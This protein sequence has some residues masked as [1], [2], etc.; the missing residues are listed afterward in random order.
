MLLL[1]K[2]KHKIRITYKFVVY[3]PL[4]KPGW[5]FLITSFIKGL[6]NFCH[7]HSDVDMLLGFEGLDCM[8]KLLSHIN[9]RKP[10]RMLCQERKDYDNY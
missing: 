8:R 10:E 3:D 2:E 4:N 7:H 6:L 5:I 9:A 1:Q